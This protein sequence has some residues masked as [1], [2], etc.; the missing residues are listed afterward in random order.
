[1]TLSMRKFISSESDKF[2]LEFCERTRNTIESATW[3]DNIV[4]PIFIFRHDFFSYGE[5][6]RVK[7]WS[8]TTRNKDF[9][10]FGPT[11]FS[12][13]LMLQGSKKSRE[14]RKKNPA[15]RR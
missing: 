14:E 4:C 9:H 15:E 11:D 1:M 6:I 2:N 3:R 7:I 8:P 13:S 5:R 12:L 10:P